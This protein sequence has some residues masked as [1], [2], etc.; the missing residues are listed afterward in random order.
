MC[1]FPSMPTPKSN[2]FNLCFPPPPPPLPPL[3]SNICL[4]IRQECHYADWE[5]SHGYQMSDVRY[6]FSDPGGLEMI[7]MVIIQHLNNPFS[8]RNTGMHICPGTR[9]WCLSAATNTIVLV[10]DTARAGEARRRKV[11]ERVRR[12]HI[13]PR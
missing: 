8:L 11:M 1:L 3:P 4:E 9:C 5:R 2:T 10:G 7:I 6:A 12:L 13:Q